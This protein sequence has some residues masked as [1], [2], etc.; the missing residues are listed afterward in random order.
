M[1]RKGTEPSLADGIE[2]VGGIPLTDEERQQV[3]LWEKGRALKSIVGLFGW[4]VILEM[5]RSYPE[6][7]ME[8]LKRIDPA[9]K[10]EVLA[11]HAVMYAANRI[12]VAFVED[13]QNAVEAAEHPPDVVKKG[14][15]A[16]H[17]G[18]PESA[19]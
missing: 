13:A 16:L 5:L 19:A 12:Y 11:E 4:D 6:S 18:P 7:S 1:S 14:I 3:L 9:Q 15:R 17:P 8:K 2:M 10:D